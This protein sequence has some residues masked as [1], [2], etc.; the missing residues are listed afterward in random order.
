MNLLRRTQET[1]EVANEKLEQMFIENKKKFRDKE[2]LW[3]QELGQLR[4][5]MQVFEVKRK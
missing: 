3:E 1:L 4:Q 5:D 2:E